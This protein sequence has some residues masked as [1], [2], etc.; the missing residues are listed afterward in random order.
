MEAI[1]LIPAYKPCKKLV[2]LCD[3]LTALKQKV[4]VVDDGSGETFAHIFLSLKTK[5]VQI[6]KHAVNLGKG[7]ALKTGFNHIL[8]EYPNACGVITADADGQHDIEDILKL[9]KQFEFSSGHLWLGKRTFEGNI[10]F[11]SK[12][13][14]TLTRYVCKLFINQPIHDTQTGLRGIPVSLIPKLL[15]TA[16]NGYDFELDMLILAAQKHYLIREMEIKTIYEHKNKSS[17]FNP[18][19]D[20]L[21]I[22]FVF[23]RFLLF[24]IVCGLLDFIFFIIGYAIF[25]QIFISEFMA[26]LLSGS[27]NFIWN[28]QLVF[29][30]KD[31]M[32]PEAL[33]YTLLCL[34]NLVF[35]YGLITSLV[36]VGVNVQLSKLISL[37]GLFIANFC[38]Q[39]LLVFNKDEQIATSRTV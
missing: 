34:I 15:K 23:F 32:L 37:I 10:P 18:L 20:S 14:N 5:G 28:K 1:I 35:S 7:Q 11:R 4:V 21:K 33:R 30:S 17:H 2:S 25:Q 31:R 39:K 9:K 16:A 27:I 13:G 6:I 3:R 26:R 22:Y 36:Y 19:I 8:N 38:I 12:F 24:S 29:K